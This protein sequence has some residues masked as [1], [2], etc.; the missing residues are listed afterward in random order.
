MASPLTTESICV[1]LEKFP[2]MLKMLI[3]RVDDFKKLLAMLEN[4]NY[5]TLVHLMR[6]MDFSD[7][8]TG[9]GVEKFAEILTQKLNAT[10]RRDPLLEA[11]VADLIQMYSTAGVDSRTAATED[12]KEKCYGLANAV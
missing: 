7:V 1:M 8:V 10:T 12:S 6:D 9:Q 4:P 11:Y 2:E 3:D 5:K